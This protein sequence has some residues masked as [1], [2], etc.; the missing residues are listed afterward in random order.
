MNE[1]NASVHER[2]IPKSVV[3]ALEKMMRHQE[4]LTMRWPKPA[5]IIITAPE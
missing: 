4:R 5:D 1:V 2:I 3:P